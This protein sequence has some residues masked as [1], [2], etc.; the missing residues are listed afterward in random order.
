MLSTLSQQ[1]NTPPTAEQRVVK[2]VVAILNEDRF[3]PLS[4]VLMLGSRGMADDKPHVTTAATDGKDEYYC[5]EFVD[6]LSDP[7]LRFLILHETFHKLYRHLVTWAHLYKIDARLANMACDFVINL[8]IVDMCRDGF[9]VM[10]KGG[11]L[12]KAFRD[13]DVAQ[14]FWMLH[15]KQEEQGGG[16]GAGGDTGESLDQHDWEGAEEM[17]EEEAKQLSRDVEQALRQG[18]ISAGKSGSGGNRDFEEM[19][20]SEVDWREALR[21]FFSETCRGYDDSTW[22]RPERRALTRGILRP[23]SVSEQVEELILANDLSA[24]VRRELGKYMGEIDQMLKTLSIKRV[25]VLWWDTKVCRE[26]VYGEG[27]T[28]PIDAL[29]TSVQ[30]TGGGGTAVRCV[31]EYIAEKQYNPS[32]VVV[33]TDGHLGG[34]WGTWNHPLMWCIVG[35]KSAKPTVGKTAHVDIT[36]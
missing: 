22:R 5:R 13:M 9:A 17:S 18:M 8:L 36:H 33:F 23:S 24:S 27:G 7:E 32:A 28:A 2:A 19:L 20:R 15:E 10:P 11:L 29:V 34:D 6:T 1:L 3:K 12:D 35:N 4:G 14:V 16:G 26:E 25:R 30:P 21:E 31:H